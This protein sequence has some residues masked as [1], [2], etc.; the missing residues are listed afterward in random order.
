M[1]RV[2]VIDDDETTRTLVIRMLG[3]LAFHEAFGKVR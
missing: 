1:A 2:L 3:G